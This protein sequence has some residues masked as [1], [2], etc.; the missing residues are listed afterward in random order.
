VQLAQSL[1]AELGG[2]FEHDMHPG[3][4]LH[5]DDA[6]QQDHPA[7]VAG[8]TQSFPALDDPAF[9][10]P[11]GAPDQ[12]ALFVVA[13]PDESTGWADRVSAATTDQ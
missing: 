1:A 11:P 2:R 7:G 9:G 10:D 5:G 12:A 6:A 4:T 3:S 8:K 13:T